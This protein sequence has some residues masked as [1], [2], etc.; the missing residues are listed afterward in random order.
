MKKSNKIKIITFFLAGI[1]VLVSVFG[2]ILS[3]KNMGNMDMTDCMF[4]KEGSG[5]CPMKTLD[6]LALWDNLFVAE[7]VAILFFLAVAITIVFL[8]FD[9][10]IKLSIFYV[11]QRLRFFGYLFKLWCAILLGLARGI[12]QPKIYNI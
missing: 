5:F 3:M 4:A 12:I 8:K 7:P 10:Q 9:K 2:L 1:L 11:Q 6:H